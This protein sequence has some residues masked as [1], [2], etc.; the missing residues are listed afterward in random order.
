MLKRARLVYVFGSILITII[1]LLTVYSS[2]VSIGAVQ[3]KTNDL[4]LTSKSISKVYDGT[5]LVVSNDEKNY[6]EITGGE[7]F[8]GHTIE[9]TYLGART[10]AGKSDN[11]FIAKVYDTN[12]ADVTD[13]Y[14]ISYEYGSIEVN[15]R[16]IVINADNIVSFDEPSFF[17][18]VII[19]CSIGVS[20][21][22]N[23]S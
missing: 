7:L 13:R 6:V 10:E 9:Y 4:V 12:K 5:P 18:S 2:L 11:L 19:S 23:S 16:E 22:P 8:S 15:K 1:T 14:N 20:N 17:Q 3:T 21:L